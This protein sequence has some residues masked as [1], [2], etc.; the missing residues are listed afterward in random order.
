MET[1]AS[2]GPSRIAA[3]ILATFVALWIAWLNLD[4]GMFPHDEGQ[5]GQAAERVLVGQLPHRDFDDMYTGGLSYLNAASFY[6]WGI[7]SISMRWML[8][9]W[10]VPFVISVYWLASCAVKPI[11]AALLTVLAAAWCI[12]MYP[13][14]MP[15]WYNL[16][17]ATWTLCAVLRYID[18]GAKRYLGLAGLAI[19]AS[20]V[21]KISG[22]FIL[23]AVL[24]FLLYRNQCELELDDDRQSFDS[25]GV[26]RIGIHP[27]LQQRGFSLLV[28]GSLLAASLLSLTFV[29]RLDW[30]MQAIHFVIPFVGLTSFVIWNE[31]RIGSRDFRG[32]LRAV[33]S[34]LGPLMAGVA[35]PVLGLVFVFVWED[36]LQEWVQGTFV[37]PKQRI[38]FASAPFPSISSLVF[39]LP[40]VCL[41]FPS[42]F[43]KC[44][45]G[46]REKVLPIVTLLVCGVLL[47]FRYSSFGFTATFQSFRHLGPILV[48][49]NLWLIHRLGPRIGAIGKQQMFVV[50]AIAFFASLIQFPFALPI[51][52]F[53]AA[54]LLLVAA[55]MAI[56]VQ[57][58]GPRNTLAIIAVFLLLFSC[59][60]FHTPRPNVAMQPGYEYR[61]GI[62]LHTERC[63]I[64]VDAQIAPVFDRLQQLI[65]EQTESWETIFATPD[66][67]EM[68]YLTGRPALNGVMYEFFHPGLYRD[69][70]LLE[71][72]L[73]ANQVNL[74]VINERPEFS[75][76]VTDEFR[77]MILKEFELLET[78]GIRIQGQRVPMYSVYVRRQ[79]D[80][81]AQR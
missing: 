40:M 27:W 2:L 80:Q 50:T 70:E 65:D 78:L 1:A 49:G 24:L 8:F 62:A 46:D 60:R 16:F 31:W 75:A 68:S 67:P 58:R 48:I 30:L 55:A 13:A 21:F 14:A 29:N 36:A 72:Q 12:P 5:L 54:P 28:T 56:Q 20:I 44:F 63:Q 64:R 79:S 11:G 35:V 61:P 7:N 59:S 47:A 15:S 17:F 53:Y 32:R 69:L 52:F 19:G 42:M 81:F 34:D 37:A 3:G 51:Y 6:I 76:P 41:L 4:Q 22:V 9:A 38:E 26:S 73:T 66:A 23:A 25:E 45:V 74:V 10:F 33:L 43:G 71:K 18:T 77:V 39:A 57:P